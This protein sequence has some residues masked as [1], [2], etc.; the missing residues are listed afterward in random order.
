MQKIAFPFFTAMFLVAGIAHFIFP[1]IFVEAMPPYLP[2]PFFLNT[3]VGIIEIFLALSFWTKYRKLGVYFSI[4][5]LFTFL[6]LI[7]IW[8]VQIGK[9][10][11]FPE[12]AIQILW[13]RVFAQLGL[14]YW[15]WKVRNYE[16]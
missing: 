16:N 6:F 5:I 11:S 1:Q 14:I 12:T 15:F 4:F 8:H 10:P 7:H 13:I 9:F 2:F 3:L